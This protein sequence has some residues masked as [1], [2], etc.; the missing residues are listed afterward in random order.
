MLPKGPLEHPRE[1]VSGHSGLIPNLPLTLRYD[2]KEHY[3]IPTSQKK[4]K[5][6]NVALVLSVQNAKSVCVLNA[7]LLALKCTTQH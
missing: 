2:G 6:C 1:R 5:I 3:K 4:C 7:G